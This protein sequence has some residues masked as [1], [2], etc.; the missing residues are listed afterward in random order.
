M[1]ATLPCALHAP[2]SINDCEPLIAVKIQT[3]AAGWRAWRCAG[4][5]SVIGMA[6]VGAYRTGSFFE[7]N[8]EVEWIQRR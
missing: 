5:D 2:D 7:G 1:E 6:A 4:I 3:N 8:A